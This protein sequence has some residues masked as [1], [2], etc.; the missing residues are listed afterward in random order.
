LFLFDQKPPSGGFFVC[1]VPYTG[2]F[3]DAPARDQHNTILMPVL[4]WIDSITQLVASDAGC[5]VASGS[6]SGGIS[7]ARFTLA[8]RPLLSV[9]NDTNVCDANAGIAGLAL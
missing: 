5:L 2:M 7:S 1:C 9:F 6:H 3:T 8:V 4:R